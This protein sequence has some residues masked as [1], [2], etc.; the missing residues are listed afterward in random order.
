MKIGQD[1]IVLGNTVTSSIF[2]GLNANKGIDLNV[3]K[4]NAGGIVL[5]LD[6]EA[7]GMAFSP[8]NTTA[9]FVSINAINDALVPAP[10]TTPASPIVH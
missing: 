3:A 4:A 10:T 8:D 5:D 6:G 1:V 9:S 2:E 7:I